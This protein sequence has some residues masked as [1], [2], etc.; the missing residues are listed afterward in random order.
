MSK[1]SSSLE[2]DF[3]WFCDTWFNLEKKAKETN[4]SE[5]WE[6]YEFFLKEA[7]SNF[8]KIYLTMTNEK[9]IEFIGEILQN[10]SCKL[11]E[12]SIKSKDKEMPF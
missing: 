3:Q 12:I 6:M 9:W 8:T 1:T 5:D 11:K 10:I 7:Q 4:K 2:N